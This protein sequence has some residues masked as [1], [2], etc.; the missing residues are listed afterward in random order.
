M[1]QF[2]QAVRRY[3]PHLH[4]EEGLSCLNLV[5]QTIFPPHLLLED[6]HTLDYGE[7][8]SLG[9]GYLGGGAFPSPLEAGQCHSVKASSFQETLTRRRKEASCSGQN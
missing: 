6:K 9:G 1:P 5:L 4:S 2:G 7:E 8:D 3:A